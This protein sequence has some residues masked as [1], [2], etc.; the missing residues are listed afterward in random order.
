MSADVREKGSSVYVATKSGVEGFSEALR[1]EVAA[2]GIKITLVEPGA[3]G[4]DM[5]D[6]KPE[7]SAKKKRKC[8]C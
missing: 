7:N 2:F 6:P 3:V 1:K 4:T 8:K 5:Q